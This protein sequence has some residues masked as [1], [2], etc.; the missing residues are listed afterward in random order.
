HVQVEAPLTYNGAAPNQPTE[1]PAATPPAPS[2]V[3][4]A[5]PPAEEPPAKKPAGSGGFF[6][7]I[8]HFFA[9]LF[10]HG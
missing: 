8:G 3:A 7:H 6:H 1:A 4:S 2:A 10:G 5:A 9:R